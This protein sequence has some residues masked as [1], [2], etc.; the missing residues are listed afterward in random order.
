MCDALSSFPSN[1]HTHTHTHARTEQNNKI[2][3]IQYHVPGNELSPR[4][5]HQPV[6]LVTPA[7]ALHLVFV[8]SLEFSFRLCKIITMRPCMN[9]YYLFVVQRNVKMVCFKLL[10][11]FMYLLLL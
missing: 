10:A 9:V 7:S 6:T 1:M 5:A 11:G 8:K 4:L 2:T 3:S